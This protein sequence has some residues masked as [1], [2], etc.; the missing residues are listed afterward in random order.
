MTT[1]M[2]ESCLTANSRALQ[3]NSFVCD[4]EHVLQRRK[5][6]EE[7]LCIKYLSNWNNCKLSMMALRGKPAWR[8]IASASALPFCSRAV[9]AL[10]IATLFIFYT[11]KILGFYKAAYHYHSGGAQYH[12]SIGGLW[13]N[14]DGS[15]WS[16]AWLHNQRVSWTILM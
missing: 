4:G 12:R 9:S 16:S 7:F 3:W 8:R 2:S 13:G 6:R 11:G 10:I 1:S 14:Q 5:N 15:F